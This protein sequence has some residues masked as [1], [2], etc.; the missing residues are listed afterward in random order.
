MIYLNLDI[1]FKPFG[2][3]IAFE[4]FTFNGGEPHIKI[5]EDINA[6]SELTITTRIRS[7]NDMGL[8]LVAADAVK[9]VGLT[10]I[11]LTL[12]YFPGARQDRLMTKGEPL[13]VKVYANLLNQI[14]FRKIT[15]LDPHSEVT[16]A[17]LN[18]V[19]VISNH[20]FVK[21][22]LKEK[23][24]YCLVS[25][26]SGALKKIYT[27][28]QSLGGKTVIECSKKRD[29]WTGILSGFKVFED[30]LK[31]KTCV[32]VDDICDGG[33]TFIGLAKELKS[34]NC[35]KL[36]LIITHGIFS[37]GFEELERNYDRIYSTN[38]FADFPDSQIFKQIPLS[39]NTLT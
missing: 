24:D 12:P 2:N 25:P 16:P 13:T 22:C 6:E 19:N 9:R 17:L 8:L 18:N 1:N 30:D 37:K 33:G 3:S 21:E 5:K 39:Q 27:L 11:D 20:A 4:S 15:I 23:L 26:D 36:I 7:F 35:G 38:S 10:K 34:K 29:V 32:I 14:G 28:S 31:K